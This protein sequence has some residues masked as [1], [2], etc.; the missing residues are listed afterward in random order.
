[1]VELAEHYLEAHPEK[2]YE[3]VQKMKSSKSWD[4][5][6]QSRGDANSKD[7]SEGETGRS[8]PQCYTCHEFGHIAPK[9]PNKGNGFNKLTEKGKANPKKGVE[10]QG[11]SLA[12]FVQ[13]DSISAGNTLAAFLIHSPRT[14]Q[15]LESFR[16]HGFLNGKQ[17]SMLRDT[18]CSQTLVQRLGGSGCDEAR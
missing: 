9:C 16:Q 3:D 6:S 11:K 13:A 14:R 2:K 1:M 5:Q 10:G 18:G 7:G 8:G 15:R 17:V 12:A 4:K